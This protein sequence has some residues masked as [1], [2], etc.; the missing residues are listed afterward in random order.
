MEGEDISWNAAFRGS[1]VIKRNGHTRCVRAKEE[2]QLQRK[3]EGFFQFKM[4][5]S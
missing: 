2:R 5:S 4:K 1:H 3:L